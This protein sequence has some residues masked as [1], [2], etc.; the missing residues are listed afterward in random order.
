M[1]AHS[2]QK[3]STANISGMLLHQDGCFL[4]AIEGE[5]GAIG[6]LWAKIRTDSRHTD[7]EVLADESISHRRFS[8]WTIGA[9]NISPGQIRQLLTLA[10]VAAEQPLL[11]VS[12]AI[13]PS[14]LRQPPGRPP[15]PSQN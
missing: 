15:H 4:Q 12:K 5:A 1:L 14:S 8:D 11:I 10:E 2:R 6:E 7:I 3:N 13:D 9:R